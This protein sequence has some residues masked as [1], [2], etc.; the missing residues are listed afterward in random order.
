MLWVLSSDT[1]HLQLTG[2]DSPPAGPLLHSSAVLISCSTYRDH[3][4]FL[5]PWG[6]IIQL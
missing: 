2:E 4:F 5:S 3:Y 6:H 1:I